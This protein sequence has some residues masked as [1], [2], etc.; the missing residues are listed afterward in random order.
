MNEWDSKIRHTCTLYESLLGSFGIDILT[1]QLETNL[2][3]GVG[4]D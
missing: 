2:R 4:D 3:L 1:D